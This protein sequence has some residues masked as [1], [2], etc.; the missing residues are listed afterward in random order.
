MMSTAPTEAEFSRIVDIAGLAEDEVRRDI[1][2]NEREREA[3]ARRFGLIALDR[4]TAT[5]RLVRVRGGAVR[6]NADFEADVVQCCVVTLAPVPA[7][8]TESLSVAFSPK[9]A[10][11]PAEDIDLSPMA[12]EVPEPLVGGAI[13][14]GETVAQY[15][16]LALD[17]YPRAPGV[18][19]EPV[20]YAG[21]EH[22]VLENS[23]FS[24]LASLRKR[25]QD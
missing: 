18:R 17:P 20:I 21:P 5:V 3:L 24:A 23:P 15:L 1:T 8:V 16:A 22:K 10:H 4:L 2:A 25:G 9:A 12:E 11:E 7:H 6:V 13:D 14:V 19:F